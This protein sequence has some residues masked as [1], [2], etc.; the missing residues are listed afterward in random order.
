MNQTQRLKAPVVFTLISAL[1]FLSL[2][3]FGMIILRNSE[4]GFLNSSDTNF[5]K[6][7][8][9][10][11]FRDYL[12]NSSQGFGV[13]ISSLAR[14]FST[15]IAQNLDSAEAPAPGMG[16]NLAIEKGEAD[17]HSSTNVQVVGIDEADIVKTDGKNIYFSS[18]FY[19]I[20]GRG[21]PTPFIVEGAI[22]TDEKTSIF[23]SPDYEPPKTKVIEAIP[24][25]D[26]NLSSEIEATGD[27]L[28][29]GN[30][31]MVISYNQITAYDIAD[32]ANPTEEWKHEFD[33]NHGYTTARL[34]NGEV[35]LVTT[36]YADYGMPCPM[37]LLRGATTLAIPCTDIYRI[38]RPVSAD[39][40]YSVIKLNPDNGNVNDSMTFIGSSGQ[41]VVYM[42]PNAIYA[43][44]TSYPSSLSFM[45]T[46]FSQNTDLVGNEVSARIAN[47]NNIDIS[48]ES[49][50]NEVGII[51]QK[52][53]STLSNDERARVE[54]ELANRMTAYLT[55]H[56]RELQRT[57]IVKIDRESLDVVAM[58]DV[59]GAPLNQFSLDEHNGNFRI[60]T[61]LNSSTMFGAGESANDLYVLDSGMRTIG[62]L[63]N[64][65]IGEQIYSARFIGDLAYL[66][67]FKQI[68][69][70]FVIDLTNPNDPKVA[71]EL[72][73]PGFSSYLHPLT[74]NK[75]LGVGQEENQS[76]LSIFDVGDPANPT[77]VE[78]Y[79]LNEFWS[80]VQSNHHAFLNDSE[81]QIFFIPS[82][83]SGYIFSYNDGLALERAVSDISA[84]R[85]LYIN[86][87][88]YVIG[89]QKI[90]VLDQNTWQQVG[91]LSL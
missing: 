78:K 87:Y 7:A 53:L 61:T 47:L 35:Y 83:S 30:K 65:A 49:K 33:E 59:A 24:P 88:L 11:E 60:A 75:I 46:F 15:G 64:L 69:P 28:L 12:S 1:V 70:F 18:E 66:V 32:P 50:L 5:K 2:G 77:E 25:Q 23:P 9:E 34:M 80:E 55:E 54:S 6:F 85:A 63:Q 84:R 89:D 90:V 14:S 72:K 68:D 16:G 56:G 58:G 44:F 40:I 26:I 52:H 51:I 41:S 62:Q 10:Q 4:D 19:S 57:S 91:S 39:T 31:L 38:G 29:S 71:G 20:F 45:A 42:S 37:P 48:N 67:T 27:L 79:T 8:S 73:I 86:N 76:K 43:T 22:A 17:R 74:E 81:K 13:G 82:G 3:V 21:V 36:R